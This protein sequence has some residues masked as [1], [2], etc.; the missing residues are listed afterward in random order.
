MER[1]REPPF[2]ADGFGSD[3]ALN[4]PMLAKGADKCQFG[5]AATTTTFR[6]RSQPVCWY[7][8]VAET[9]LTGLAFVCAMSC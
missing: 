6:V 1:V 4:A 7:G 8:A 2:D 5:K 9:F 3:D